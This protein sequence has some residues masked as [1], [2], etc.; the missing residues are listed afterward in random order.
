MQGYPTIKYFP[1]QE[2]DQPSDFQGGR[3][4]S[5]MADFVLAEWRKLQPPPEVQLCYMVSDL[6][7]YTIHPPHP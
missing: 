1:A 5:S 2:K 6:S 4:S 7:C 3:D